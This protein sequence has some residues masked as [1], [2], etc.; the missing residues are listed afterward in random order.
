MRK[1]IVILLI[2]NLLLISFIHLFP[3]VNINASG[4]I[5]Y[6]DVNGE[7]EYTS[8]Q[9]AIDDASKGDT[10]YVNSGVYYENIY[11]NYRSRSIYISTRKNI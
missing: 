1:K 5:I 4:S 11:I 2:L 6:V 3:N 9:D 10:I 8:I 7:E